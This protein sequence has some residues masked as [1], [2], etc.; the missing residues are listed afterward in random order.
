MERVRVFV[1]TDFKADNVGKEY[2]KST[3]Y[4]VVWRVKFEPGEVKVVARKNGKQVAVQSIQTAG[5]P[6][7]IVL[8]RPI[9]A[10]LYMVL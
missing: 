10:I 9:K 7:H 4:H 1:K 5:A 6:D 2:E 3:E 8:K